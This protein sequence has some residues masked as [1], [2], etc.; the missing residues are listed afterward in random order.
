MSGRKRKLKLVS[1]DIAPTSRIEVD[2]EKCFICQSINYSAAILSPFKSPCFLQSSEKLPCY[3]VVACLKQFQ[4][5]RNALP[6]ILQKQ[7][8][9]AMKQETIQD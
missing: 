6:T 5:I 9:K 4:Q 7:L 1:H 8:F 3:K 2:W